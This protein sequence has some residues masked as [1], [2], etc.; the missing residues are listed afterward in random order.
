MYCVGTTPI[1]SAK[2]L[3]HKATTPPTIAPI[4]APSGPPA[5][6]PSIA[7]IPA[8]IPP[9]ISDLVRSSGV[10][11]NASAILSHT[12][13][14]SAPNARPVRPPNIPP[15]NAFPSAAPIAAPTIIGRYFLIGSTNLFFNLAR[16][17][18]KSGIGGMNASFLP[19]SISGIFISSHPLPIPLSVPS[20]GSLSLNTSSNERSPLAALTALPV[21][22]AKSSI[23]SEV[24]S[25]FLLNLSKSFA[26]SFCDGRRSLS[27]SI[28]DILVMLLNIPF[29]ALLIFPK[30]PDMPTSTAVIPIS[31]PQNG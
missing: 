17:S 29:I 2:A 27:G 3:H 22:L 1:P 31:I 10:R 18:L 12:K 20:S 30:P 13:P 15:S 26:L 21:E 7:P 9:T 5:R 23:A 8:P 24:P 6:P 16:Y 11:L 25:S 28:P 4:L 14:T 19:K